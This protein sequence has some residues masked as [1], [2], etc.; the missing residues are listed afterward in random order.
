MN[1]HAGPIPLP[2]LLVIFAAGIVIYGMMQL[3]K[4]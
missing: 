2:Q 3:R 4:K 1:P